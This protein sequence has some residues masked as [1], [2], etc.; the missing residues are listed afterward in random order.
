MGGLG[1]AAESGGDA[2]SSPQHRQVFFSLVKEPVGGSAGSH[3]GHEIPCTVLWV[4][5]GWGTYWH[6]QCGLPI[7]CSRAKL[8]CTTA[9]GPGLAKSS[10]TLCHLLATLLATSS[11]RCW[12][13]PPNPPPP[14]PWVPLAALGLVGAVGW[15]HP[16]PLSIP[17]ASL[18]WGRFQPPRMFDCKSFVSVS[19]S[20]R[21][22]LFHLLKAS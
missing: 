4:W 11:P 12:P 1:R 2:L 8:S 5:E 7:L 16:W 3:V 13:P 20:N 10:V 9:C 17:S 14:P 21:L 6:H 15:E 18:S 19:A 22:L